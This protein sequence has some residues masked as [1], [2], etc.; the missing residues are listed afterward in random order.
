MEWELV[1][2]LSLGARDSQSVK[3]MEDRSVDMRGLR[4]ESQLEPMAQL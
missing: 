3:R 2:I 4:M 1:T